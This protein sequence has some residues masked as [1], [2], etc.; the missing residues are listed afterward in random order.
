MERETEPEQPSRFASETLVF[1]GAGASADAGLPTAAEL[2]DRLTE[3]LGP[4]YVN[5]ARLVFRDRVDVE[6]L[7]RVIEFIHAV[8]TEKRPGERR[9]V[10]QSTDVARLVERWQP[11]LQEYLDAQR[12][13]VRGT[14]TGS[15]IDGLFRALLNQLWLTSLDQPD[16]GYLRQLLNAMRG[17]TIVTINYDNTLERAA[18][19]GAPMPS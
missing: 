11:A 8:E 17:G 4:L 18:V 1:L 13:T 12:H 9:G 5:L 14:S 10:Y 19:F 3:A 6:R 7:F 16:L 15:L 2:H